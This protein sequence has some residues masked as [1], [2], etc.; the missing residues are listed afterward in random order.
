MRKISQ[1]NYLIAI[2]VLLVGPARAT[3]ADVT[4]CDLVGSLPF[5]ER[6]VHP[7]VQT[8]A[9][10]SAEV[11]VEECS[12]AIKTEPENPRLLTQ[13]GFALL[14]SNSAEAMVYIQR[15]ADKDYPAAHMIRLNIAKKWEVSSSSDSQNSDV[16]RYINECD[17]I[18]AVKSDLARTS[19]PVEINNYNPK[20]VISKCLQAAE[21]RPG[22]ARLRYQLGVA[23]LANG[24]PTKAL[25]ELSAASKQ[26]YWPAEEM[27]QKIREL[28]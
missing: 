6:R 10:Y 19:R 7:D 14:K 17:E 20:A 25:D 22:Y 24:S 5:D 8:F 27:I 16:A 28:E 23:Y 11:V 13:L 21:M 15:A 18:G 4:A 26:G 12:K 2:S 3:D 9:N 1:I